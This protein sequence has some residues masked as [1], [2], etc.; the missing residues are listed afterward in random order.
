MNEYF[1]P[2]EPY[3]IFK[4][5]VSKFFGFKYFARIGVPFLLMRF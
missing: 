5:K 3:N 4:L 1:K 2:I